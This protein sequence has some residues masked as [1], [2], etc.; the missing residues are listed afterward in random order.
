M[1]PSMLHAHRNDSLQSSEERLACELR[2][3]VDMCYKYTC[4]L[5]LMARD[6][7]NLN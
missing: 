6:N 1:N 2:Y 5:R 3:S 7:L 4:C